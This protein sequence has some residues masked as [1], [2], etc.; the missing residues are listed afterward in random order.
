MHYLMW[1]IGEKWRENRNVW[2]KFRKVIASV[3]RNPHD[4]SLNLS[5]SDHTDS[6]IDVKELDDLE[7]RIPSTQYDRVFRLVHDES[8]AS[9]HHEPPGSQGI[10]I[11]EWADDKALGAQWEP[12]QSGN[13]IGIQIGSSLSD[14][15]EE[16]VIRGGE[17]H[18]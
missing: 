4:E 6:G 15:Y 18:I 5:P 14:L 8:A 11:F 7:V 13:F 9:P 3:R 2:W 12:A 17:V 16:F 1:I 10:F